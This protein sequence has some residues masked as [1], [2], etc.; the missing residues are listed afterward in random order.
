M[1]RKNPSFV[2]LSRTVTVTALAVTSV[3]QTLSSNCFDFPGNFQTVR[4]LDSTGTPA[5]RSVLVRTLG[6]RTPLGISATEAQRV[7]LLSRE[8]LSAFARWPTPDATTAAAPRGGGR[9]LFFDPSGRPRLFPGLN[10]SLWEPDCKT[11]ARWDPFVSDFGLRPRRTHPKPSS[12]FRILSIRCID[13]YAVRPILIG[14]TTGAAVSFP[15]P[16]DCLSL[17]FLSS[18]CNLVLPWSGEEPILSS[19]SSSSSSSVDS[20]MPERSLSWILCE[21]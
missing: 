3:M 13:P 12:A 18:V 20:S 10:G 5:H 6:G 9:G 19:L 17:A 15:T 7:P 1:L 16:V 2:E 21:C 14:V 4:N 11:D 8:S